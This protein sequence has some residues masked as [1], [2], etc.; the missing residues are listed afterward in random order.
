MLS[1]SVGRLNI[2]SLTCLM[3]HHMRNWNSYGRPRSGA[4]MS[5]WRQSHLEPETA[6]GHSARLCLN[7][8]QPSLCHPKCLHHYLKEAGTSKE[9]L[10]VPESC[11]LSAPGLQEDHRFKSLFL[12]NLQGSMSYDITVHYRTKSHNAGD[13]KV[14]TDGLGNTCAPGLKAWR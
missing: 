1:I 9:V 10:L 3:L 14:R 12:H 13:K 5:S 8:H 7:V 11:V 2:A 6:T 4:S